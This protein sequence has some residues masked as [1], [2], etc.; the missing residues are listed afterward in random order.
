MHCGFT[1]V[2]CYCE[3]LHFYS[4]TFSQAT[5]RFSLQTKVFYLPAAAFI[6]FAAVYAVKTTGFIQKEFSGL[7]YNVV[8][9]S[10]EN[11]H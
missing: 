1:C 3:L 7:L 11:N 5:K 4:L 6:C 10:N 9:M 8:L 2:A